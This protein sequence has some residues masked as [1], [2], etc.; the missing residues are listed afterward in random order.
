MDHHLQTHHQTHLDVHAAVLGLELP[1]LHHPCNSLQGCN[2]MTGVWGL[3]EFSALEL[4]TYMHLRKARPRES[5]WESLLACVILTAGGD[6]Y[7]NT[8]LTKAGTEFC[9]KTKQMW[10]TCLYGTWKT[11]E[12]YSVESE[13]FKMHCYLMS[14][15]I[16]D[17]VF[18]GTIMS[19]SAL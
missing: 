18:Y 6:L 13:S 7:E 9:Y 16:R 5:L 2:A 8:D 11:G 17:T 15:L 10:H 1:D 4:A 14:V 3:K 19:W 12:P